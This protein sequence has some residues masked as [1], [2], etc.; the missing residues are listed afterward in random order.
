MQLNINAT[1]IG[2]MLNADVINMDGL[3]ALSD[4]Q[5]AKLASD[6]LHRLQALADVLASRPGAL[7]GPKS[8]ELAHE[9][10]V[11][12][13]ALGDKGSPEDKKEKV[14]K[15]L[16][17]LKTAFGDVADVMLSAVKIAQVFG[18]G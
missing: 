9:T 11:L 14:G 5:R 6:L 4:E 8:G 1:Q 12:A 13:V 17:F 18:L 15:Y 2:Q 10:K 3:S 16:A 7:A